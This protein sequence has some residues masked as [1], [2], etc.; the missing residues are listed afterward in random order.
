MVNNLRNAALDAT[1]FLGFMLTVS[2][3]QTSR[4]EDG[5]GLRIALPDAPQHPFM[6]CTAGELARLREAYTGEGPAH[7]VVAARVKAA[8]AYVG[9]P[10]EFPPRGGQHNQWYQCQDCQ[11]GLE[12]ID[13]TH[14]RCPKCEKVYSGYP[15]DDRVFSRK[16]SKNLSG[17]LAAAWAYAITQDEKYAQHAAG[18]LLGYAA[19]YRD[20]PYHSNDGSRDPDERR[21]NGGHLYEQ[22]LNEA[23]ALS[24]NIA[25]A[26]DLIHESSVL[27][28]TNHAAIREGL[29]LPMLRNM[30]KNKA[31][32]GNWQSWHNAAMLWGGALVGDPEWVRKSILGEGN[33]FLPQMKI[34]V[35]PEGM[36]YENS[37]AYHF[38][39]LRARGA[40]GSICGTA[41]LSRRCLRSPCITRWPTVRYRVLVTT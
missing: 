24:T 39:T 14:H 7:E 21:V 34:S 16:H 31:G 20:Y 32:K 19:R 5:A 12:T 36:W 11:M 18:V 40:S 22:T 10:V 6:A 30:D 38:Y 27:S 33:G 15:Y 3:G 29:L 23:S 8:D 2:F 25:P 35:M 28:E 41:R 9:K 37:W 26:Y 1:L 4:A 13:D 17:M